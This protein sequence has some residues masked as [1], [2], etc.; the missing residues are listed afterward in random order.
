MA[1]ILKYDNKEEVISR[2]MVDGFDISSVYQGDELIWSKIQTI[3]PDANGYE[4]VDMG[5]SVNWAT[6]NVGASSPE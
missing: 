2:I 3:E 6:C 5:L 1:G 4:F